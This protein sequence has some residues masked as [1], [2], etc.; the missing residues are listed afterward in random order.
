MPSIIAHAVKHDRLELVI[1]SR[2]EHIEDVVMFLRDR[3]VRIGICDTAKAA[4]LV[5]A[6]NE[7]ITNAVV[8]G[9]LRISSDLKELQDGSFGRT[10]AERSTQKD[11][12]DKKVFIT[13]EANPEGCQWIIRDEGPGFDVDAML[14]KL[15]AAE[16]SDDPEVILSSGRG[17][18]MMQAFMDDVSW[19]NGGREIT[20][21]LCHQPECNLH[22]TDPSSSHDSDTEKKSART[23]N[24]SAAGPMRLLQLGSTSSSIWSNVFTPMQVEPTLQAANELRH[25]LN[26]AEHLLIKLD[27]AQRPALLTGIIHHVQ[28][29]DDGFINITCKLPLV[30][31]E[32][33]RS[34]EERRGPLAELIDRL[35]ARNES[36]YV[37]LP[38]DDRRSYPRLAY[39][40][41]VEV[42][43]Q[44]KEGN[45]QE[46][47]A[48]SRDISVSGIA[49]IGK[50]TLSLGKTIDLT[51]G[52]DH[53]DHPPIHLR[54]RVI[55]S[56][57]LAA[58]FSDLGLMFI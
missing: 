7:A 50:F 13:F 38:H 56:Q 6:L 28:Q 35:I 55:R 51:V 24:A 8:H 54:A 11:F 18:L 45:T 4:Q 32:D 15:K 57:R 10:L 1:P 22:P 41:P 26:D 49:L 44:D 47:N 12:A 20:L 14:Q 33:A 31:D 52:N 46:R 23:N 42:T 37:A 43:I 58:G 16:E 27:Y 30:R 19:Q 34:M 40:Q 9:N 21:T 2:V 29:A 3:A 25:A 48:I 53:P 5:M 36:V 17:I 39:T